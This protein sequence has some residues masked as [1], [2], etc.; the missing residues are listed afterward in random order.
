MGITAGDRVTITVG[1]ATGK[2]GTVV[3][4][5]GWLIQVDGEPTPRAFKATSFKALSPPQPPPP[6]PPTPAPPGTLA[7]LLKADMTGSSEA[8]PGF[9]WL[10]WAQHPVIQSFPPHSNM[11]CNTAWAVLDGVGGQRQGGRVQIAGMELHLKSKSTGQWQRSQSDF[12]V[13]DGAYYDDNFLNGNQSSDQRK[14]SVGCSVGNLPSGFNFHFYP[15]TGRGSQTPSDVAG[16]VI[17]VRARLLPGSWT[18]TAPQYVLN[19][20]NDWWINKT[21]GWDGNYQNNNGGI[22]GKY[23]R[24]D[25][26]WRMFTASAGDTSGFSV[27]YDASEMR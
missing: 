10:D 22:V 21:A 4:P 20:A 15:S 26:K 17:I 9:P 3:G 8:L 6:P 14:E 18:G 12:G 2:P 25:E 23:K 11:Q 16:L 7:A 5:S 24:V 19:A 1:K 27:S 13:V